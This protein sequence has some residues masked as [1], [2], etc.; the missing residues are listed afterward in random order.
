MNR[1][2]F[3]VGRSFWFAGVIASGAVRDQSYTTSEPNEKLPLRMKT[4]TLV[5]LFWSLS[6]IASGADTEAT[7]THVFRYTNPIT[8]DAALSL[9]DHFIIKDGARWF[10]TGTSSPVWTGSNPGVRLLVSDD[11]LHWRHHSWLIDSS[12]LPPD[13]P[14]NGR[15]WA[16]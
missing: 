1:V 11:L 5:A 14:Y 16:P 4:T 13:C 10:C 3:Y 6:T 8:R 9:R 15:F 12:Q 7:P 2:H